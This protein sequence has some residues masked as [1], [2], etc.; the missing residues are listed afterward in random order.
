M[1]EAP[2]PVIARRNHAHQPGEEVLVLRHHKL[3]RG[4]HQAFVEA[5]RRGVWLVYEKIGTRVVGDFR[6]VYPDGDGPKDYDESYRLARYASFEHWQATRRPVD[7]MG[8]G[9]LSDL[10]RE[11]GTRRRTFLIGSDGAYFM[12]G[13]MAPDR[14]FYMPGLTENYEV[15]PEPATGEWAPRPVRYDAPLPGEE[16]MTLRYWKI[17]KG[18][19]DRFHALSRDGVWPFFSKLGARVIGQWRLIYPGPPASERKESPDY[20]EVMMISRYASYEHWQATRRPV[21]LGGNGP[22]YQ[23]YKEASAE[24]QSLS[25]ESSVKFLRGDFYRSPPTY[26]PVLPE[27][28]R[29][30]T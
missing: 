1:S 30:R 10:G 4:M 19:F 25:K 23:A 11:G 13:H 14:P 24:R 28:Y 6:I 2:A 22:D 21:E 3:R 16:I 27:H 15:A 8:N 20:D 29:Q 26:T 9:P 7:M 12:T 5:S 17:A 18:S